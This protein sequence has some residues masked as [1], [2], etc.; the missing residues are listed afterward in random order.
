MKSFLNLILLALAA[1]A[2]GAFAHD[3]S[4]VGLWKN[5]DDITGK[6]TALIRISEQRG[7][8]NGKI[9]KLYLAPGENPNPRCGNCQGDRKDQPVLGMVFMSGLKKNGTEYAG[10]EILDP[11]S[12][13]V[14]R[15]KLTMA[16]GGKQLTVRGYIGVSMLGR[17]QVWVRQD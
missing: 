5:I 2:P 12:G 14:Y 17:S 1:A 3:A 13:K 11:D 6:P 7:E 10:G 8:L 9:E 4:P 15:S 16:E